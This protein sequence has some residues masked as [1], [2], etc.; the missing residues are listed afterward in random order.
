MFRSY[1][2]EVVV[3]FTWGGGGDEKMEKD[4]PQTDQPTRADCLE[5]W[6]VRGHW[7]NFSRRRGK[8]L[9]NGPIIPALFPRDPGLE[10][11][12]TQQMDFLYPA[13]EQFP[14]M[15]PSQFT[16]SCLH[17]YLKSAGSNEM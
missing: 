2:V 9:D 8:S 13:I 14:F 11:D 1:S 5:Y 3:R 12:L 16:G 15:I 10:G 7:G 4:A 6:T 17:L